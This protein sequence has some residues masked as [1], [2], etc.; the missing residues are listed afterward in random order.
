M[1]DEQ[2]RGPLTT[3]R[4]VELLRDDGWYVSETIVEGRLQVWPTETT[5]DERTVILAR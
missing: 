4:L 3:E 5:K 1:A 2:E